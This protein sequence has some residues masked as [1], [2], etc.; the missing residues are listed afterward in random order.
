MADVNTVFI[1]KTNSVLSQM[2]EAFAMKIS[3]SNGHILSAGLF[4]E[5]EI[6]PLATE[7]MSDIGFDISNQQPK[8][9]SKIKKNYFNIG[10]VLGNPD[11]FK[12]SVLAGYSVLL[13]WNIKDPGVEKLPSHQLKESFRKCRDKIEEMVSGYFSL[14]YYQALVNQQNHLNSVLMNFSD[15]VL[16]HDANRKI[17]YFSEGASELMGLRPEDIIGRDCHDVF[18]PRLCGKNCSF[19]GSDDLTTFKEKSYTTSFYDQEGVHKECKMTVLPLKDNNGSYNGVMAS[20]LNITEL[21]SLKRQLKKDN[22]FKGIIGTDSQMLNLFQQIRDIALYDYPV[23]VHG[24]TGSGKELVAKAIHTESSRGDHPFVPIN[25]G[26]LP[27]GLIESELF[28][29]VKGAFS[30]AIRDKKGRFELANKGTIF[31]DEVAEL[32]K[33]AQVKLLR[34]LQEGKLEKIGGEKTVTLDVRIISA[35]NKDL[36]QE[37][38]RNNFREDLFYRLNV[39]PVDLP[40][41]R[42]RKNDI[43]LL[44]DHFLKQNINPQKKTP[45]TL[46][47]HAMSMLLNHNWPGNVRELENTIRFAIVKSKTEVIQPEDMPMEIQGDFEPVISRGPS[48]KLQIENVKSVLIKTGGNKAKAARLLGV[49]RATLYRFL[50]E[51]PED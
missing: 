14:G 27:E 13:Y 34:V 11:D 7:V 38:K 25:C 5:P 8:S 18:N 21:K 28:G 31:L 2:A 43:P 20:L 46:S 50:K 30:G 44:C 32:P 40:P 17:F 48:K 23:H 29:H 42:K 49:G 26:A 33:Q 45:S 36:K 3:P 12:S 47:D 10:I 15:A 9:I 4:A 19:C 16:A 51:N 37:V 1:C 22:Q 41:L 6:H 24:E 35:T 39:I